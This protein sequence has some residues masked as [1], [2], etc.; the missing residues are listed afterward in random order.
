MN[1]TVFTSKNRHEEK[2]TLV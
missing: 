1:F 2:A